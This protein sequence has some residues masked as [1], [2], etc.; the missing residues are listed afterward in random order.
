MSSTHKLAAEVEQL[1]EIISSMHAR[2]MLE[3][4]PEELAQAERTA[5]QLT[6]LL[7]AQPKRSALR[8][9]LLKAL[10]VLDQTK[11]VTLAHMEIRPARIKLPAAPKPTSGVAA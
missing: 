3:V 8:A 9:D 10:D 7:H 2:R 1:T 11:D 6:E 4:T 5:Q